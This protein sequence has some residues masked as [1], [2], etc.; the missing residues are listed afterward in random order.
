VKSDL[1][2]VPVSVTPDQTAGYFSVVREV[3]VPLPAGASAKSY[4]V[5][6]GFDRRAPG[7][8]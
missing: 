7:A 8:S 5:I 1:V 4:R 3:V 2:K 6:I